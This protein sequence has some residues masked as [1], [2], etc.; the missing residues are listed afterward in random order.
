[1]EKVIKRREQFIKD[2]NKIIKPIHRKLTENSE[3]IEV[4]YKK[5]VAMKMSFITKL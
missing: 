5:R 3:E 1:M 2:I 4:V